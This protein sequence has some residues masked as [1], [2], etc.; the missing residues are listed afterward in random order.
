[1]SYKALDE[2]RQ[3]ELDVKDN[4]L[5]HVSH[6]LRSPLAAAHL[7]LRNLADGLSGELTPRQQDD[8]GVALR[9]VDQLRGM[10]GDLLE[11]TRSDTG[12]LRVDRHA[13]AVGPLIAEAV[14]SFQPGAGTIRLDQQIADNLPEV[15]ADAQ[16]VRQILNN[17]IDNAIKFT[18]PGG[19]I[20][21]RAALVEPE[22]AFVRVEV[23]DT[24]R[25][26]SPD[27]T[28]LAFERMY[29]EQPTAD[30]PRGGL[31]LGLYICKLLVDGHG[32][33]IWAT[34]TPGAGSA[35]LFTLPVAN[36]AMAAQVGCQE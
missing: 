20:S 22:R 25:G 7:F 24:G 4:F 2:S 18:P 27:G 19:R 5:A 1:L 17:L 21:V 26:L 34:S 14:T 29:Q 6:E 31:G 30:L 11:T 12:R 15:F 32:G 8:L 16:R 35:F 3:R 9:N 36:A 28:E 33:R 10:I 13:I 23:E